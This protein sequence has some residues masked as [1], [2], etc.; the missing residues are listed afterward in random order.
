MSGISQI[1]C[2]S[3]D[4]IVCMTIRPGMWPPGRNYLAGWT[5]PVVNKIALDSPSPAIG[6]GEMCRRIVTPSEACATQHNPPS[7]PFK[8]GGQCARR[9]RSDPRS[10][11]PTIYNTYI[12][13]GADLDIPTIPLIT[14]ALSVLCL[15]SISSPLGDAI[16]RSA[17]AGEHNS[18][19]RASHKHAMYSVGKVLTAD[20][21]GI[22]VFIACLS[23][24]DSVPSLALI[25][26]ALRS[27]HV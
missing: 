26:L 24:W 3:V 6:E 17:L 19:C 20:L 10:R 4:V 23:K 25:S 14:D 27:L 13:F 9:M 15:S 12:A 16:T 5:K 21:Q 22:F 8:I 11:F 7:L 2:T 18:G 1:P